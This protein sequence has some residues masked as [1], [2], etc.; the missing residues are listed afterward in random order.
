MFGDRVAL[1]AQVG[2][3]GAGEGHPIDSSGNWL[4]GRFGR[5]SQVFFLP[6]AHPHPSHFEGGGNGDDCSRRVSSGFTFGLFI[7]GFNGGAPFGHPV[8]RK[9][10]AVSTPAGG[11]RDRA[12]YGLIEERMRCNHGG[13]ALR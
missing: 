4:A 1:Q 8:V 2:T 5:Y 11:W 3:P 10:R 13:V 9:L 6:P 12:R 7:G